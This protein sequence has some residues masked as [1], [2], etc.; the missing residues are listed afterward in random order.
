M[1]I[2]W[3]ATKL[4]CEDYVHKLECLSTDFEDRYKDLK[5][6]KT[7]IAF[8]ENP[9]VI[10]VIENGCPILKSISMDIAALEI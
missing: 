4:N 9:F 6:L 10:N 5:L 1:R 8:L 2:V 7:S 3:L